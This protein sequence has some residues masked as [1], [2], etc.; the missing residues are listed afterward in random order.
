MNRASTVAAF[1]GLISGLA[2][3][4]RPGAENWSLFIIVQYFIVSDGRGG[5]IEN[6][7]PF[8]QRVLHPESGNL[9]IVQS[10]MIE[11]VHEDAI[12]KSGSVNDGPPGTR[13]EQRHRLADHPIFGVGACRDL[14][15]VV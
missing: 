1:I 14:D 6:Q 9:Y 12:G 3:A 10:G 15:H 5:R 8:V 11:T 7:N 13:S 2:I 4:C